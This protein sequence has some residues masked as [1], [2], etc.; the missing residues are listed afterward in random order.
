[1]SA[2]ADVARALAV[3]T[4]A[5]RRRRAGLHTTPPWLAD[6]LVG[7]AFSAGTD[8]GAGRRPGGTAERARPA[9]VRRGPPPVAGTGGG[10][11]SA[12]GAA[13]RPPTVCDPACGG[14]AFLLAAAR[15]LHA[16]GVPRVEVVRRALWG[17]DI[18]PVGLAA[19]E[20]A[21]VL[22]AGEA[23]PPG[24]LVVADALATGPGAWPD[25]PS[26]G[27]EVVVGNPP[28]QNQLGRA[29]AR[30]AD[31]RRALRDRYGT[32]VR[33]YTDTAWL[34]LLLAC[35]LAA[36][37]GRVVLIQPQSIVAARDAAPV[38]R[39]LGER[40][41]LRSLWVDERRV[42]DA[43][44]RVCAP[45]LDA[46]PA[47]RVVVEGPASR[48]GAGVARPHASGRPADTT[49]AGP[50]PAADV[51]GAPPTVDAWGDALADALGVP[52]V[53]LTGG[54]RLGDR[55]RVVAGFRDEYYGLVPL[56]REATAAELADLSGRAEPGCRPAVPGT[57]R[58][59]C[60]GPGTPGVGPLVTAGAITWGGTT[61]G[62]AP[63]RFAR[64]RWAA[65]VV[66]L[67]AARRAAEP[68]VRRWLLRTAGPKVLVATQTRVVEAAVD[69]SGEWVPS[70]PVVAV[71]PEDPDDVWLLAAAVLAPVASAWLARRA[72]GTALTRGSIRVAAPHLAALPLPRDPGAWREAADVLRS[73]AGPTSATGPGGPGHRGW[74]LDAFVAA[75]AAAYGVDDRDA[76]DG[77]SAWWRTRLR[78]PGGL[79]RD[80][81]AARDGAGPAAG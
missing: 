54:H 38:R 9:G 20:A 79:R 10:I 77:A 50:D 48:V 4:G 42:F 53:R 78:R 46:L 3:A 52:R 33:A 19:A 32:A 65:P 39:A 47:G 23:P 71:V 81:R 70:I 27:F 2:V 7:L 13:P 15:A 12:P 30:D 43:A 63:V 17:A 16:R 21:L 73:V 58:E 18:D 67:V 44:V 37:G 26:G 11:P 49:T 57:G 41:R 29:T 40:A 56:V 5:E 6:E 59:T 45:V 74:M 24:R 35:D 72:P 68:A 62:S 60:G 75:A 64:R 1:V 31:D 51:A 66:D 28:F 36:P 55:A 69:V 22:W 76:D 25:R 61:W 14:G 8:T 34:F 80:A